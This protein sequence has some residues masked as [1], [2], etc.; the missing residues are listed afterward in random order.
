MPPEE[1]A[2][3]KAA[4]AG[5]RRDLPVWRDNWP[6]LEWF[7]MA[8]TQWRRSHLATPAGSATVYS[9]LDYGGALAALTLSGREPSAGLFED[10]RVME[11]AAMQELNK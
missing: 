9:G 2:R 1:V 5:Q 8:A 6:A 7:L 10:L 4:A 3:L 11:Y